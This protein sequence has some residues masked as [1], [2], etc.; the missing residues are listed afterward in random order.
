MRQSKKEVIIGL[1]GCEVSSP[2]KGCEALSY[3][4]IEMIS[5]II[6]EKK[7]HF[8]VFYNECSLDII[9]KTFPDYTFECIPIKLKDPSL[10]SYKKLHV[11]D[12]IFDVT[13]GDSFSDIYSEKLC[14]VLIHHKRVAELVGKKYILLP[15][16]YGPFNNKKLEKAAVKVIQRADYVFSRDEISTEFL[17]IR[18]NRFDVF[19]V[20]DMAFMLPYDKHKYCK[21]DDNRITIGINVS[22]LLWKGGFDKNNQFNL[23][24]DYKKYINHI[25][26][27]LLSQNKYTIHLIPHVVD[28]DMNAYD[29][30]YKILSEL[31]KKYS[32][33]ILAPPFESPIEAKSYIAN[34]DCF[35]GARMHSTIAAYSSGV[36]TI[37]F[38]YSRK[39]E[40]LFGTLEYKYIIRGTKDT[41]EEAISNTIEYIEKYNELQ[42]QSKSSWT[43]IEKGIMIFK[44]SIATILKS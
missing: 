8:I 37:P 30:D 12:Y 23:S 21:I 38:S 19:Q 34:M 18:A 16:T 9:Q 31:H 44:N 39:F 40:G 14:R 29:D 17:N 5:N 10:L 42:N 36:A 6:P 3:S 24:L 7:I 32:Q 28:L 27:W 43:E 4:F 33:T 22:G 15:Q 26:G 25:I 13:M 41:F 2:N 20:P 11:C 35:I 1:M